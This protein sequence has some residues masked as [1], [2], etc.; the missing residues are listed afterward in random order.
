MD[1]GEKIFRKDF[2]KLRLL[3]FEGTLTLA[4]SLGTGRG[5]KSGAVG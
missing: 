1:G 3:V 2:S 4:L 5:D